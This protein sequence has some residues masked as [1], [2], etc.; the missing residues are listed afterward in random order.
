MISSAII[1]SFQEEVLIALLNNITPSY[2]MFFKTDHSDVN[3]LNGEFVNNSLPP[4]YF[5]NHHNLQKRK[6][7]LKE[8]LLTT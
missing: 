6:K 1:V 4:K 8:E 5:K 3:L 2:S 7:I